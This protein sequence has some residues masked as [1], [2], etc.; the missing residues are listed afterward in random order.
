[1]VSHLEMPVKDIPTSWITLEINYN[2]GLP[3]TYQL[4]LAYMPCHKDEQVKEIPK[5]GIICTTYLGNEEGILFDA[6][7]NENFR[8]QIFSNI[9]KGKKIQN[10]VGDL[11]FY[12]SDDGNDL[13]KGEIHSRVLNAEQ[14][15]TSLIYDNKYFLKLYR[16]L[17][18]TINPDLEIT[19]YL[20]EKTDYKNSPQ[21]VGAIEFN[22]GPNKI[23]VLG[24]M[25]DLIPN[26]GDAW[27]YTKDSLERYFEGV[28][29]RSKEVKLEQA[30]GELTQPIKYDDIPE[31]MKEFLG[32]IYPERAHL[33]GQRTAEMHTALAARPDQKDFKHEE[34]SLHYQ[35]SVYSSLQSLTRNS[36]QMLQKSLKNLPEE[37]QKEAKEVL[38]MKDEVLRVF[39]RI[40]DH[41]IPVMKIRTHGDYHLGQVLWTGKDFII[42]DFEGEPARAFSE[43]RLKRSP[44]RDVAG[45]V[46]SFHYAA[47]SSIMEPEFEQQR[48]DGD[49]EAWA[50]AWYY[51]ITRLYLQGYNESVGESDFIPQDQED[52]KIL[53]ET[54]LLEKAVYELNYELNNRPN[55]VLIPLRGIK[56]IIGRYRNG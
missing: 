39:K 14:S 48:K 18:S 51:H 7:Y 12:Q 50:E 13:G 54:F 16:K 40:Y 1:M 6:V 9:R 43:R 20:S 11:V 21:F 45:M 56:T 32:V 4:P 22:P 37:I 53:M 30:Q 47:Y 42:I 52:F 29:T 19:R 3:E 26:Q 5:K 38:D 24:M 8:N 10:G 17:D 44:L 27:D 35:R 36:F 2:D 34:F 31:S 49:L 46:R 41:K 33:L 55:W 23:I 15:N 28:M 25:Q